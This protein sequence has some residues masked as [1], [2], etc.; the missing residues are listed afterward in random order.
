MN[1]FFLQVLKAV[2][3]KQIDAANNKMAEENLF[4]NIRSFIGFIYYPSSYMAILGCPQQYKKNQYKQQYSKIKWKQ[5]SIQEKQWRDRVLNLENNAGAM[6]L[7]LG[8]PM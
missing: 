3:L 5:T 6:F 8:K 4:K 7:T 2:I 1:R